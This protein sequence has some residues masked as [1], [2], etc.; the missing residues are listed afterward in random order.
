MEDG[1]K[2]KRKKGRKNEGE[3]RK[4]VNRR[5]GRNTDQTTLGNRD[6]E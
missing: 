4:T 6:I 3:K 5:G 1:F 2:D